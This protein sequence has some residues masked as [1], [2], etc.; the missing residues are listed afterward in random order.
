MRPTAWYACYREWERHY[1]W[2]FNSV[3][4][5]NTFTSATPFR[6]SICTWSSLFQEWGGETWKEF[7]HIIRSLETLWAIFQKMHFNHAIH[8]SS[9]NKVLEWEKY[10]TLYG[11][12]I[13]IFL[14][15]TAR[16]LMEVNLLLNR[17]PEVK[18]NP[19]MLE[20]SFDVV[21]TNFMVKMYYY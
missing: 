16:V 8:R 13:I 11:N 3:W 17:D 20:L 14:G 15:I 21:E 9:S 1:I 19:F 4:W 7:M 10:M 6:K 2:T 18:N 12:I 5:F